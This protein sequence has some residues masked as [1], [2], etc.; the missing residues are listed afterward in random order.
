MTDQEFLAALESCAL[1]AA[2]F[3]HRDHLRAGWLYLQGMPFGAALDR[4]RE[5]LRRYAASHG[6]PERYHETITVAYMSLLQTH[7]MLRPADTW[8]EFAAAN[9]ALFEPRLLAHFYDRATLD[10]ALAR[11]V[12][13]L[14]SR[15]E[16]KSLSP[17]REELLVQQDRRVVA[18]EALQNAPVGAGN[19]SFGSLVG[20][21]R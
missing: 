18:I 8:E 2:Q 6:Q 14:E 15:P 21:G 17:A 20:P 5:T 11:R 7:R 9:P 13:V 4:M 12:F 16:L 19:E 3:R 1:P 10:S